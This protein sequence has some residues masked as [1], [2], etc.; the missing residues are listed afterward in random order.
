LS[1]I[2]GKNAKGFSAAT[3][4]RLKKVWEDE[5]QEWS[6]RDLSKKEY[7]YFWVDGVYFNVR[8]DDDR[9]CILVIIASDADG[10][11]ELLA[12]SDGFR[13]SELS[14]KEVLLDL[15]RRGLKNYPKLAVG[16]SALG[17]FVIR[18]FY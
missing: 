12:I 10:N 7:V 13:E 9:A 5:Y 11:K 16:D 8:L 6:K 17:F 15:K 18:Q 1:A 14:W 2:L 4:V 3:I